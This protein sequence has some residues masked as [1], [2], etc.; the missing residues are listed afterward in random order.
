MTAGGP[1]V[2][3]IIV[4]YGTAALTLEAVESVLAADH[5]G[6]EVE[7]HVVDNASPGGDADVLRAAH[8]ERGWQ[9]RVTLHLE[10][11]NHGFGRGNNLVLEG[12]L[13]RPA[14]PGMALLLN[15]D[16]RLQGDALGILADFL[17]A[18]PR[19]GAAGARITQPEDGTLASSAFRF[20]GIASEFAQAFGFGPVS[21]LLGGG[22]VALPAGMPAG[23]V[24]W[25][26]GAA[27]M[28]RL[29]ALREVGAF[30]PDFF[31]YYEEVELMFRL[32]RAGW[33]IW[34]V[35]EAEVAHHEGAA[36]G[37]RSAEPRRSRRPDYWYDSFGLYYLK[38]RGRAGAL[39]VAVARCLG[40][41]LNRP[42]ALARGRQPS[43]PP[44]GME[45]MWRRVLRPLLGLMAAEVR[46]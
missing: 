22:T 24:D 35:A 41:A 11:V 5:G 8:D 36:T 37:V 10:A 33:D 28:L 32:R 19:V 2:A 29:Q 34:H 40:W 4:N 6:R 14:P 42:I 13:A 27:V 45:A 7:L 16:A 26:A 21:R 12:L 15:P 20:P 46:R 3:V 17:D 23:P 1:G 31:L 39:M 44:G 18:H 9:G 38:T 43:A 25:V 30:D